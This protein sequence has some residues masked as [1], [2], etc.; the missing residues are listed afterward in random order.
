MKRSPDVGR[1]VRA[2][3]PG[4]AA[5]GV[6]HLLAPRVLLAVACQLYRLV[7]DVRFEPTERSPRRVRLVGICMVAVGTT[8]AVL[9]GNDSQ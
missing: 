1:A 7:L 2:T 8:I 4:L 5:L 3:G 6:V 9:R